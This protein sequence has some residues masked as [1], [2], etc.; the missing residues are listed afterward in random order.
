MQQYK[1]NK[2][3]HVH[4]LDDKPLT[5]TSSVEDVLNK[6]LTWWASGLAVQK[7]GVPDAKVFTK[8]KKGTETEEELVALQDSVTK[9]L[10]E[11]KDYTPEEYLELLEDAYRAHSTTLKDKAKDGT[12]LHAELED[13]V[14]GQMGLKPKRKYDEKI[15]PFIDWAK[16]NVDEFLW[17]EAHCFDEEL[18]VGGICDAGAKLKDGSIA[19]IDFKSAKEAYA[20]HFIQCAGYVI[21]I[22]KNGL[23]DSKGKQNKKVDKIDKLIVFPFGAEKVEPKI[24]LDLD[25][26]KQ[27]FRSCV[28]LYRLL[29]LEKY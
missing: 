2:S 1:F 11:L 25:S 13:Y 15:Q 14:K 16:E 27:G 10:G 9:K 20:N 24:R 3:K 12:D 28:Q 7:L 8:I 26:Y 5:G 4:L 29:G 17:S 19:L 18:W 23:W 6:P 21:Q 22:E